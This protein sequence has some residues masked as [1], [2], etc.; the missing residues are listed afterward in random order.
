[1]IDSKHMQIV[2]ERLIQERGGLALLALFERDEWRGKWDFVVAGGGLQD[3]LLDDYRAV[4]NVLLEVLSRDEML[5]IA[6]IVIL[7]EDYEP[8]A[9]LLRRIHNVNGEP[10]ELENFNFY[11]FLIRRGLI[12]HAQPA[13]VAVAR[14]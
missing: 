4:G 5:E 11:E 7:P 14:A 13:E 8:V 6:K 9:H 10:V 3:D 1:M 2:C 12:F